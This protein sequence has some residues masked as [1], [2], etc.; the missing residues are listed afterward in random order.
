MKLASW[1]S[2]LSLAVGMYVD[3]F[4]LMFIKY[5]FQVEIKNSDED[6]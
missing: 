5:K 6:Q 4:A 1:N 2:G 3:S